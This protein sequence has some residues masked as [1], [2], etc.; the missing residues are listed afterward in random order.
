MKPISRLRR[1]DADHDQLEAGPGKGFETD[2]LHVY[3][4]TWGIP[5][6]I[7]GMTTAALRRIR[8]FQKYGSPLS[9]T[10]LTFSPR[11]DVDATRTR[12]ISEGRMD[13]TV[14]LVNVWQDLRGRSDAETLHLGWEEA[15]KTPCLWQTGKSKASP[16]STMSSANQVPVESCVATICVPT[17]P[18]C[19]PMFKIRRSG[20]VVYSAGGEPIAEWNRPPGTSTMPGFSR[21]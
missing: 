2:A 10:L 18:C 4:A 5:E 9:Q 19:S 15:N 1:K 13:E 6:S 8:S 16:S 17:T 12:L 7:G 3:N 14:E 11:M 20:A 21:R